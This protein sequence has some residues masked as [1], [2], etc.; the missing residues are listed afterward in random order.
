MQMEAVDR[1]ALVAERVHI[2]LTETESDINVVTN[3][4]GQFPNSGYSN[5]VDSL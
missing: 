3:T 4:V 5:S 1:G 2:Q